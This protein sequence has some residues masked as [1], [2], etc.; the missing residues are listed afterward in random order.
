M[1]FSQRVIPLN[2]IK[3]HAFRKGRVISKMKVGKGTNIRQV[4]LIGTFKRVYI[5][6]NGSAS[7]AHICFISFNT[8]FQ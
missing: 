5:K 2:V 7:C 8:S 6:T 3:D 1:S 4:F